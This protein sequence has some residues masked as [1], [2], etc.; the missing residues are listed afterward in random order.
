[1]FGV[2]QLLLALVLLAE[3]LLDLGRVDV[4][5][6]YRQRADIDDV[7]EQLALARSL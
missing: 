3:E 4:E 5:Q 2:E 1:M 7:L 6:R